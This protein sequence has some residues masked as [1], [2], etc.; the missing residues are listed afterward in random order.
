MYQ[1]P[2]MFLKGMGSRGGSGKDAKIQRKS[3]TRH[4]STSGS[5][6]PIDELTELRNILAAM[7]QSFL[8]FLKTVFE[9]SCKE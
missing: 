2:G 7:K 5:G 3:A 1:Y 8:L 9:S 4:S 6:L